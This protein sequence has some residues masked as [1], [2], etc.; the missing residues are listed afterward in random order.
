MEDNHLA[1]VVLLDLLRLLD[2]SMGLQF[3]LLEVGV[4]AH[5]EVDPHRALLVDLV[6][7]VRAEVLVPVVRPVREILGMELGPVA[8]MAPLV[9]VVVEQEL[10]DPLVPVVADLYG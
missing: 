6:V 5:T 9:E 8:V 3:L 7:V 10:P 1:P 2:Y 4:E